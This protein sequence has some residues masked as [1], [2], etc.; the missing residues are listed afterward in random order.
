[1]EDELK[2]LKEVMKMSELDYLK[3]KGAINLNH[4]KR[5]QRQ[6]NQTNGTQNMK[7]D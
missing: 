5:K 1:M 6:P 2:I 7:R 3:D 4:L